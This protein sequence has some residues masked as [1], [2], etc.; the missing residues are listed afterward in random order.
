MKRSLEV[1]ISEVANTPENLSPLSD[2]SNNNENPSVL[3]LPPSKRWTGKY[4]INNNNHKHADQESLSPPPKDSAQEAKSPGVIPQTS[5]DMDIQIRSGHL[6]MGKLPHHMMPPPPLLVVPSLVPNQ[7]QMTQRTPDNFFLKSPHAHHVGRVESPMS[8][9]S[10]FSAIPS[11]GTTPRMSPLTSLPTPVSSGFLPSPMT[12]GTFLFSPFSAGPGIPTSTTPTH[13]PF[14][15][16]LPFQ[17]QHLLRES[18]EHKLRTQSE[19][20]AASLKSSGLDSQ[21]HSEESNSDE[22][23]SLMLCSICSD[24]ATGLHYGIITCEGC[25]GFFKRTVQNKR[26]YTCVGNGH[27][28]VTKAQRNRCQFCRF[29]KCLQM[30][31]MLEAVREDR[32][33][34]GR[35]TGLSYKCKP[36]NYDKLRKKFQ[37]M[38]QQKAQLNR[39]TRAEKQALKA[40]R[41][42]MKA[43]KEAKGVRGGG[44][45]GPAGVSGVSASGGGGGAGGAGKS[46]GEVRTLKP[47]TAQLI[48]VLQQTESAVLKVAEKEGVNLKEHKYSDL[49]ATMEL[50][51]FLRLQ[52]R[53]GEELVFHLVQ[54]VRHLPF[55]TQLSAVEHT[56]LLKTKWLELMLLCTIS[57]AMHFKQPQTSGSGSSGS[58]NGKSAGGGGLDVGLSFEQCTHKNLLLLQECMNKTLDLRLDMDVFREEMGEVVEKVTKLAASFRTLG[59]TRNEYLLLKVI[60]LLDQG[61]KPSNDQIQSVQEPYLLALRDFMEANN[62]AG[63]FDDIVSQLPEL[64]ASSKLLLHSKLLYMPYLL[65]AIAGVG[66]SGGASTC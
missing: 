63:R 33:P 62:Q 5:A 1:H 20:D 30:G 50:D 57:R 40:A 15:P 29:Q 36:K 14:P 16:H 43:E 13:F 51:D 47:Q 46:G 17:T 55:F 27:C 64:R 45:G 42:A 28:E 49:P 24:K 8:T 59:I 38:A 9:L 32:M 22:D 52:C 60:L 41:E 54:W 12:A 7:P 34:G 6:D 25:K 21:G 48:E 2:V 61:G 39:K 26:V 23:E 44:A 18:T 19:G 37:L 31:M 65:N 56:Y 4:H 58:I 53:L 11:P 35:N 66:P 3:K 10:P